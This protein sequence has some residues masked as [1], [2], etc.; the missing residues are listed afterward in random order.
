MHHGVQLRSR[1][2]GPVMVRNRRHNPVRQ[3]PATQQLRPERCMISAV[4]HGFGI[5][6][7]KSGRQPLLLGS[8][9]RCRENREREAPDIVQQ[10]RCPGRFPIRPA[11][12]GELAGRTGN[13]L[14]M[15]PEFL[16]CFAREQP[17][18]TGGQQHAAGCR[19]AEAHHPVT[20]PVN[21]ACTAKQR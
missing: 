13:R 8:L 7:G 5:D 17:G 3:S 15:F 9:H 14:R 2:F 1:T 12:T 4:R 11:Q 16:Q 6:Q 10:P 20:Q 18:K 21:L 19:D